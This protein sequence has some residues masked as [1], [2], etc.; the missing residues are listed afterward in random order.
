MRV[1]PSTST[2][3]F[4]DDFETDKGWTVNASGTDTATTGLFER[5]DPEETVSASQIKQLGTTTSGSSCLVTGR[6]AGSSAGVHDV[7]GGFTSIR[8]AA[9]QL[10][11]AATTLTFRYSVAHGSN[12]S[13]SDYLRVRI[14]DGTTVTTL[15][16]RL[17][18]ATEVAGAWQS[19]SV[20][21]SAY[22]GRSVRILVEAGDIATASLFEAQLDDLRIA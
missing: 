21:L 2:V 4:S 17:G 16:E 7:D 10:P 9:I 11:S 15:F 19:A 5:G 8:S 13:T 6:L 3:V 1:T 22:S 18:A 20:S 12:S 14:V